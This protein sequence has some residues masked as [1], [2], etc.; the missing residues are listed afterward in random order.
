MP[1]LPCLFACDPD[2]EAATKLNLLQ[3]NLAK[4]GKRVAVP[5][6]ILV[7]E[8]GIV[9]WTHYAHIAMDRPDPRFVLERV[10][11]VGSNRSLFGVGKR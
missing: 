8:D 9:R 1:H 2:A 3:T 7:D 10:L 4:M 5:S 6:N 11:S